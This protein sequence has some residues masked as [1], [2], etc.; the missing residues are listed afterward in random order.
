MGKIS[1][2]LGFMIALA[3]PAAAFARPPLIYHHLTKVVAHAGGSVRFRLSLHDV[4]IHVKPGNSVTVATYIW[5]GV[6]SHNTKERLIKLLA[7]KVTATNGNVM[8]SSP[9][10]RGWHLGFDWGG[11]TQAREVVTMPPTMAVKYDLGSGNFWFDNPEAKNPIKGSNGSGDVH[12]RSATKRLY[13]KI[14]SGDVHV[15]LDGRAN[16]VWVRAG[17]G[18]I[19][20]SG[21]GKMLDLASGSGDVQVHHATA[22]EAKLNTGSGDIFAHWRR[23]VKNGLIS[24]TSGSG[25]VA[26][27]FPPSASL[28]GKITTG[29]GDVDSAFPGSAWHD[30]H[31]YTLSGSAGAVRL[32]IRTGSGDISLHKGD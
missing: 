30:H 3:I 5:S 20:F 10:E 8:V 17:S 2:S 4:V 31:T 26:M 27:Y 13:L 24:A 6:G 9:R 12:I 19:D 18:D 23:V 32:M 11:N 7:P 28:Q 15:A 25:D 22:A 21:A 1:A 14:G 29:S 16:A